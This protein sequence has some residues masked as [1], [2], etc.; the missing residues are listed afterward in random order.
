MEEGAGVYPRIMQGI[1]AG[2]SGHGD[3]YDEKDDAIESSWGPFQLNRRRGLGVEFEKDTGLDVRDPKTIPDQTRWVANYIKTHVGTN[4]QW[5]G[6]RGPRNA[7]PSWG[8]SGYQPTPKNAAQFPEKAP[9]GNLHRPRLS[10]QFGHC[11][12]QDRRSDRPRPS[13][14]ARRRVFILGRRLRKKQPCGTSRDD[15][16]QQ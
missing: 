6:Y 15:I 9:P 13:G 16:D 5:M 11:R 3:N 1:C 12:R 10:R 7:N 2:E 4:G 8:N 14:T